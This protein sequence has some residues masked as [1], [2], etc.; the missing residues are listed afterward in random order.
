MTKLKMS[1]SKKKETSTMSYFW[2]LKK[3]HNPK[4]SVSD[5]FPTMS[6]IHWHKD[7]V[8]TQWLSYI[9]VLLW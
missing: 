3:A 6:A 1:Y 9:F 4:H 7:R 8:Q 5:F 2:S